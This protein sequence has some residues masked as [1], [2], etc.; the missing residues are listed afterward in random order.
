MKESLSK[1]R[2]KLLLNFSPHWY[3]MLKMIISFQTKLVFCLLM[4]AC[5]SGQSQIAGLIPYNKYSAYSIADSLKKDADVV[6]REDFMT[7]TIKDI[8]NATLDVHSLTT[9]MNEQGDSHLRFGC[10]S[11]KF[12]YLDDAEITVYNAAGTKINSYSKKQMASSAYGDGLVDDGKLTYFNVSAPSYPITV[13]I[14]YSVKYK[15][16]LFYPTSYIQSPYSS[17][18]NFN[19]TVSVPTELGLRFKA[20]NCDLAPQ[21]NTANGFTTY[22]WQT[23][24]L[25]AK[26]T[27]KHSG[28]SGRYFPQIAL[29]PNKFKM[30]QYE[31]DM[32]SWQNF[33]LW[34]NSMIGNT[35]QLSA[36]GKA[37]IQNLVKNESNDKDKIR[38]IYNYLQKEMRYVSIQLGIGGWKPFPADFVQTK[39]YGDCKALS[40]YMRASLAAIG[41]KSYYALVRAGSN[42]IPPDDNFPTPHFNHIIVCVPQDR[43][44]IWLECTSQTADF[45][46][47]GDFTENRKALLI[48]DA[49]GVLVPTPVS[50]PS[51]NIFSCYTNIV[52]T[53]DGSGTADAVI[54]G[55]GEFKQ[56]QV[57]YTSQK[58]EDEKRNFLV[59][60]MEWKQPDVVSIS[61]GSRFEKPYKIESKMEYDQIP[62]FKAGSKMFL[63]PRLYPFFDEDISD[64]EKRKQDYYFSF[65]YQSSDTTVMLLPSGF[66]VESLPKEKKVTFPFAQYTCKY[67]FDEAE[68]T[69]RV[70]AYLEI[71]NQHLKAAD[72]PQLLEF[73]KAVIADMNEKIVVKKM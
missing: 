58:S 69:V 61:S 53:E 3:A 30:D 42:V 22:V 65:P 2:N 9:V 44:S 24:N 25:A 34:N 33:G 62:S 26:T 64:N 63:Q 70:I 59:K 52:L 41:I 54:T 37:F 73:K 21:I 28:G 55:T 68:K 16:T 11:D 29:A 18:E 6:M 27:E 17:V 38:L 71:T 45:G 36:E 47:L 40:N 23:K 14:D 8:D 32:S 7:F 31:G 56:Q 50:K 35:N 5:T 43:D 19:Y 10:Y 46:E 49:G 12:T 4:L 72:Y 57:Y 15:G 48:T 67:S 66:G 1:K 51:Q 20:K 60:S 39:K 13:E